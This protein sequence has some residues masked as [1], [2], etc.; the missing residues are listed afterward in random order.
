MPNRNGIIIIP[1][2]VSE[3]DFELNDV[4]ARW[5]WVEQLL[6]KIEEQPVVLEIS[7]KSVK[8][9]FEY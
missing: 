4:D 9:I 3:T 2:D 1:V 7:Q 6:S 5:D 8:V